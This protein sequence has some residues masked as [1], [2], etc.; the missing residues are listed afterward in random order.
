MKE[1]AGRA[2]LTE[3]HGA[4]RAPGGLMSAVDCGAIGDYVSSGFFGQ[5]PFPFKWK[6]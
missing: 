6:A 5:L 3:S 4:V 1:P 2:R